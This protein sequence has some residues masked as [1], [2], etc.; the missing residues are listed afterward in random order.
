MLFL[1]VQRAAR[2]ARS[3]RAL[4]GP[5][6]TAKE[7]RKGSS[8]TPRLSSMQGRRTR[9][10]MLEPH[11]TGAL[12]GTIAIL[13]ALNHV[14]RFARVALLHRTLR[15]AFAA[16]TVY[17]PALLER[18]LGGRT[19]SERDAADVRNGMM[20]M[21]VAAAC[22]GFGWLQADEAALRLAAGIA[23]FPLFVGIVLVISGR[24]AT[25]RRARD[26]VR[27]D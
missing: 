1:G 18:L 2:R 13:V 12:V 27:G 23:L 9:N 20:L 15:R 24:A 11:F 26:V 16:G 17:D 19:A 14:L 21:A 25:R 22:V 5:W 4:T 6:M 3:R 8:R 10:A 7:T